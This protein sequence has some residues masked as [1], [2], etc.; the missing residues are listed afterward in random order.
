MAPV[1]PQESVPEVDS[2][3]CPASSVLRNLPGIR[4][5]RDLA[6]FE[7]FHTVSRARELWADRFAVGST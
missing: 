3:T 1:N 2:Y 6:E 5:E 7:L 4:D